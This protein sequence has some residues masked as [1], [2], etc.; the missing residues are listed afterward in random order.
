M[1]WNRI[2]LMVPAASKMERD[3]ILLC[4]ILNVRNAEFSN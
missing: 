1:V 3:Q 4:F 2:S